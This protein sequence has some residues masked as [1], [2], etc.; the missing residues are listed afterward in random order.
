MFIGT[1]DNT[2]VG[3]DNNR[4]VGSRNT[5]IEFIRFFA[6]VGVVMIHCS[7]PGIVGKVIYGLARFG[8]P[9]FLIVSGYFAYNENYEKLCKYLSKRI[10]RVLKIWCV[11]FIGYFILLFILNGCSKDWIANN[12]LVDYDRILSFLLLQNTWLGFSWY[13]MAVVMCYLVTFFIGKH[14]LWLKSAI[15]I[16]FLLAVNLFVGE[17]LPFVRGMDSPWYWCSNFW[18]L[19]LPFYMLGYYIRVKEDKAIFYVSKENVKILLLVCFAVNMAERALT[20]AS[21]LFFSNILMVVVL[22]VFS[23]RYPNIFE[24]RTGMV[25]KIYTFIIY[26]GMNSIYIYLLHPMFKQ[27]VFKY[28]SNM[29]EKMFGWLSAVVVLGGTLILTYFIGIIKSRNREKVY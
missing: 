4:K 5:T 26:M 12:F 23:L 3:K 14:Q 8:V 7:F 28:M 17:V 21:Q 11:T 29:S 9:F 6:A 16:P 25:G 1:L 2:S 10:I 13:L 24:A 15:L 19:A 18:I 22:F 20:H 27:F